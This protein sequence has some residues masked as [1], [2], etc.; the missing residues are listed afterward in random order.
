MNHLGHKGLT[1]AYKG[2]M[3]DFLPLLTA[4]LLMAGCASAK[5]RSARSA[6]RTVD[7]R[8]RPPALIADSTPNTAAANSNASTSSAAS[9]AENAGQLGWYIARALEKSPA[10]RASYQ[11][12]QAD[13]ENI[14]PFQRLPDPVVSFGYYVQAV[15]TRVGPQIA[16]LGLKQV[17][18]WPGQLTARADAQSEK[19]LASEKRF[20][21]QVVLLSREVAA[22]YYDLWEVR[23]LRKVH[24]EHLS[25]LRQLGESVQARVETGQA[26]LAD[27]QQIHLKMLTVED[28]LHGSAEQERVLAADL[29]RVVGRPGNWDTPTDWKPPGAELPSANQKT[30][31]EWGLAH[32]ALSAYDHMVSA[33]EQNVRALGKKRLPTF[34][35]GV[36]WILT[37]QAQD[38]SMP[39]SGKDAVI[40]GGSMT[41]PIFQ[42]SYDHEVAAARAEARAA[43]YER[44]SESDTR[45]SS[46]QKEIARVHDTARRVRLHETA[47]LPQAASTMEA[48]VGSYAAGRSS[49]SALLMAAESLLKLEIDAVRAQA[50]H[51]QAW[52]SLE[53]ITGRELARQP[54]GENER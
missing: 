39:E 27:L 45:A 8:E 46:V 3:R 34:S 26:E 25:L 52:A 37:G 17:I 51:A 4:A 43:E 10:L 40:V 32:P 53:Q 23:E 1:S 42:G 18:P 11:H 16:R 6:F 15:E 35:V 12:F 49:I 9:K 13:V 5:E 30:L 41:I 44:Q 24:E 14:A 20:D 33:K 22:Y 38:P 19:A 48:V 36:D 21:A 2:Q 29:R 54:Y 31:T 50:G 28:S 47:L 7:A